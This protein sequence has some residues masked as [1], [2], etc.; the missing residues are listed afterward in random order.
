MRGLLRFLFVVG[1]FT[2]GALVIG[3]G[4]ATIAELVSDRDE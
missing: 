1:A 3:N 4:I 2:L